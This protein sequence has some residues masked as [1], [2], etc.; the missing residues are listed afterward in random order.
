MKKQSANVAIR[1]VA[2]F[3]V[4]FLLLTWLYNNLKSHSLIDTSK[5]G[6]FY[7]AENTV[8]ILYVGNSHVYA[9]IKPSQ[10]EKNRS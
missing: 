6:L 4:L 8:D 5:K 9:A 2:F 7:Q 10:I 3:I 1:C